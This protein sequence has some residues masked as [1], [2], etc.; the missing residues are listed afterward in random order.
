MTHNGS[1]PIGQHPLV[2]RLM[3]GIY[4][5]RPPEPQYSTTWDVSSV[6]DW[7]K[8]L[9]N[10]KDLSLKV[11]SG[12]LALLMA[13]VSANR[14]SELHT[15]DLRFRSYAHN[16]V[17]F[18]LT[19]LTKKQRVGA[20]LKECFFASFTGDNHLCVVQCLKRYDEVTKSHKDMW[21]DVPAPLFLSYIKPHKPVT[22]KWIAH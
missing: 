3:K 11:L 8:R 5:S 13:L 22:S 17:R 2:S 15:L 12:K 20:S 14:T 4:N 19:S 18:R 16:G 7:I 6:L 10:N 9:G 21:P 1:T